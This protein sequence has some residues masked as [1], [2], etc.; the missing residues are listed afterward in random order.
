MCSAPS[1][2]EI[3]PPRHQ[4]SLKYYPGGSQSVL[5]ESL[6]LK[7]IKRRRWSLWTLISI[8]HCW[9]YASSSMLN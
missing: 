7:K 8:S 6:K 1:P 2:L 5:L 3:P 4:S 9:N